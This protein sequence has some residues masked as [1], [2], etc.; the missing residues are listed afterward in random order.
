MES[1]AFSILTELNRISFE[2]GG[3]LKAMVKQD[4]KKVQFTVDTGATVSV[5]KPTQGGTLNA[6]LAVRLA[7]GSIA[8]IQKWKWG[9]LEGIAGHENLLGLRDLDKAENRSNDNYVQARFIKP[10]DN[11]AVIEKICQETMIEDHQELKRI[12]NLG[13][14]SEY[15]NDVGLMKENYVIKGGMPPSEAQYKINR[16]ALTEL[17]ETIKEL[18]ALGVLALEDNPPCSMPI[19][20]VPKPDGTW[21]M[22]HD[23]RE[24]NRRTVKDKRSLINPFRTVTQLQ[25]KRFKTC[26]D[27]AN[28]FWSVPIDYHSSLKTCFTFEGK[29]YRW[30][31]LPQG[32]CN[33]PN[34][35][36]TRV[37]EVLIGLDVEVYID[38][39]YFTHEDEKEH[40]DLLE[41][42]ILRCKAA[43]LK[44]GLKKCEIGKGKIKYLGFL[45]TE[46][47]KAPMNEYIHSAFAIP[48]TGVKDLERLLGKME[49]ISHHIPNYSSKAAPLHAAKGRLASA[50]ARRKRLNPPLTSEEYGSLAILKRHCLDNVQ[51]LKRRNTGTKSEAWLHVDEK[52]GWIEIRNKGDKVAALFLSMTWSCTESRFPEEEKVLTL[53]FKFYPSIINFGQPTEVL[54][55]SSNV[56]LAEA[57]K[58][59]TEGSRALS[60]RWGKWQ[61]MLTDARVKFRCTNKT[62]S[63]RKK[64]MDECEMTPQIV[65]FTD[66]SKSEKER[67]GKWAILVKTPEGKKIDHRTGYVEGSAQTNE[68]TALREALAWAD[69]KKY[70]VIHIITDSYYC[71][72][73]FN[74]D[75]AFWEQRDFQNYRGKELSHAQEWAVIAELRKKKFVTVEHVMSHTKTRGFTHDGNREVDAL[76]QSREDYPDTVRAVFTNA[77]CLLPTEWESEQGVVVPKGE[78]DQILRKIHVAIGH[79]GLS[80]TRLWLRK[81]KVSIP[82]L[83]IRFNKIKA[84]CEACANKGGMKKDKIILGQIKTDKAGEEY[85]C[86][87]AGPLDTSA[88]GHKYFLVCVDNAGGDTKVYPIKMA[89]GRIITERLANFFT[90]KNPKSVRMD[91]ATHF[92]NSHVLEFLEGIGAQAIFSIPYKPETNGVAERAV[93]SA[94][95]YIRANSQKHWDSPGELL[96]MNEYLSLPKLIPTVRSDTEKGISPFQVGQEVWVNRGRK[97]QGEGIRHPN[98]GKDIIIAVEHNYITLK[99]TGPVH[100]SQIQRIPDS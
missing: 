31:R 3:E 55:I 16:G 53:A 9:N 63:A 94:K 62:S 15:K 71:Y 12:L 92:K 91:N 40:L 97:I 44:I 10:I 8:E 100:P 95:D 25:N 33:S 7:D 72:S 66:G 1:K 41:E 78:A 68:V 2:E 13:V 96:K 22:V 50:E 11:H 57:S 46:T 83:N 65:V 37:E 49:Y 75:L 64:E 58:H 17:G 86:D 69:S 30:N 34:V 39:I 20:A 89:T 18:T 59:T 70:K 67:Y 42:V 6:K 32:F 5:M 85:S 74:E 19:Q 99:N 23:L 51:E 27:L 56:M 82:N 93:R 48:A 84:T 36:Q 60:S 61:I 98:E 45:I 73:G 35:F 79:S 14:Y 43:G 81:I 88:R 47:G 28:G 26:L 29:G 38:D 80:R 21:R 76:A 77:V 87:V 54:F 4:G 52:G 24:L 90:G